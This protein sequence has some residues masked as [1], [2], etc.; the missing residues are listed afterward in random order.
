MLKYNMRKFLGKLRAKLGLGVPP[1]WVP[2][3][4]LPGVSF[5]GTVK[6]RFS[7]G[8][9]C[10]FNGLRIYCWNPNIEVSIGSFCAFAAETAIIAGGEHDK[11]WVASF[12][13]IEWF[14]LTKLKSLKKPRWKGPIR[15][16]NDV[17]VGTRSIILSGVTLGDGCVIG[18]GAVVTKSVRPYAIVGGNPA[19]LI[20]YRF[21]PEIIAGLL[22]LQWWNWDDTTIKSRAHEFIDPA[23]FVRKYAPN[24]APR[25]KS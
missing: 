24:F 16:G 19:R 25:P 21:E 20:R 2:Y 18:A 8:R 11:D 5:I 17:W 3:L 15:I 23:A 7:S 12:P 14:N 6:P 22:Q 9:C 4:G 10:N 13:L 1:E